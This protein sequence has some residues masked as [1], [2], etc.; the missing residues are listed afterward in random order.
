VE[1]LRSGQI[2]PEELEQTKRGIASA[3]TTINDSPAG[4]IDRNLIGL[5]EGEL[6]TIDQVVEAIWNV[7]YADCVRAM[8]RIELDTTY[9]LR[10]GKDQEGA[11]DGRN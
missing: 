9:I 4:V 10:K 7:Q 2:S 6:R 1:A 3:M 11:D 8:Q 5:V